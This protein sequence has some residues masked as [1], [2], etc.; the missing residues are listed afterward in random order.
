M[1]R[2]TKEDTEKT[3]NAL[4]EAAA[5]LFQRQG[6][7]A[8]TMHEIAKAAG[9]TRGAFYWHFSSKSDVVKAI[10][11]HHAL[12]DFQPIK[13]RLLSLPSVNPAK[14]YREQ[15]D[16]MLKLFSEESGVG[17]AMF[18]VSHN[19]EVSDKVDGLID[20]MAEQHMMFE[21]VLLTALE[22]IHEAGQLNPTVTPKEA[23]QG[24]MCLLLGLINKALLPFT[25][26]QLDKEGG[27][28]FHTYLNAILINETDR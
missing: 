7:S 15:V 3:Y 14:V 23:A 1:A 26:M 27:A 12:P 11:E 6:Y 2:K 10:W 22:T 8:T 13:E 9:M 25:A 24:C 21:M 4:L 28:I 20:F 19:M 17:R 18:I 5:E 16:C